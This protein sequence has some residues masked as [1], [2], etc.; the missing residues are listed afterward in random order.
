MSKHNSMREVTSA[1]AGVTEA[2][3]RTHRCSSCS[4]SIAQVASTLL[5][6]VYQKTRLCNK[7]MEGFSGIMKTQGHAYKTQIIQRVWWL[8]FWG[9]PP[10]EPKIWWRLQQV[11]GGEKRTIKRV[12]GQNRQCDARGNGPGMYIHGKTVSI[13]SPA[14]LFLWD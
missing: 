5:R 4:A 10:G 2:L 11:D 8:L 3:N 13:Q 12:S 14:F 9:C 6:M 7:P 1:D